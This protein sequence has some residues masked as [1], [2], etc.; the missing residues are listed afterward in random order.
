MSIHESAR[1]P[2]LRFGDTKAALPLSF[3]LS[4]AGSPKKPRPLIDI[5]AIIISN[6]I[7][8]MI[9]KRRCLATPS[10]IFLEVDL[11]AVISTTAISIMEM[12]STVQYRAKGSFIV[13]DENCTNGLMK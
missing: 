3:G 13:S 7:A 4:Q 2:E 10:A 1:R 9:N 12:C 11:P 6:A 5:P 8:F